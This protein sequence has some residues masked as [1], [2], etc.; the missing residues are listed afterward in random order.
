MINLPNFIW[1]Q[2]RANPSTLF[3]KTFECFYKSKLA[4]YLD[5]FLR[6]LV[7]SI[8]SRSINCDFKSEITKSPFSYQYATIGK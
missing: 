7:A 4:D 6:S 8:L 3:V 2:S 5:L 1:D